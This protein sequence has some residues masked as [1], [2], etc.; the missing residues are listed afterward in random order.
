[1]L[2]RTNWRHAAQQLLDQNPQLQKELAQLR[3]K[4]AQQDTAA[5]LD[6]AIK[7]KG[8]TVLATQIDA[9]D[10]DTMRQMT[11]WLRDKLGSS[12]VVVGAVLNDKP[13]LVAAATPDLV[14][15][16]VHAG[17]LVR[18]VAKLLGGGGGGRP[19]MAQAGGKDADKLTEALA[20]VPTLLE[21]ML[22]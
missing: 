6:Q 7:V 20:T 19:D 22:S 11:D 10:V 21:R 1:M 13:Q 2:A 12:V 17:H 14:K 16:G 3:Q 5:L 9:A 15:R 18:D 8:V 4:L